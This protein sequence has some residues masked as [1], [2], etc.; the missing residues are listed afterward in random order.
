MPPSFPT[1]SPRQHQRHHHHPSRREQRVPSRAHHHHHSRRQQKGAAPTPTRRRSPRFSASAVVSSLSPGPCHSSPY[2][3]NKTS[4]LPASLMPQSEGTL[5]SLVR[6]MVGSSAGAPVSLSLPPSFATHSPP[7]APSH[8]PSIFLAVASSPFFRAFSDSYP[9]E[10]SSP[11]IDL[12]PASSCFF[13]LPSPAI[14]PS[15]IFPSCVS[16]H[17]SLF[18]FALPSLSPSVVSTGASHLLSSF[19][20][21]LN[22]FRPNLVPSPHWLVSFHLILLF[23]YPQP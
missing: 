18:G 1:Q 2:D 15:S 5:T 19:P 7:I 3:D 16:H 13:A 10:L 14:G 4:A 6:A 8:A 12:S 9:F 11:P 21:A 22:Y 20:L 23:T 17:A